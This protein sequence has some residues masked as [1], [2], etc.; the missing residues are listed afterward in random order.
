MNNSRCGA[1]VDAPTLMRLVA[2]VRVP[3]GE[4]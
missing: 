4:R 2:D 3:T 1:R